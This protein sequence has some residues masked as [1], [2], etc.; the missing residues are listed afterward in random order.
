MEE[1]LVKKNDGGDEFNR[2][3]YIVNIYVNATINLPCTTNI[4]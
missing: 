4:C 3:R 2:I 1:G